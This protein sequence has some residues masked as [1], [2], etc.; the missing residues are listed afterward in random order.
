MAVILG[1]CW[2]QGSLAVGFVYNVANKEIHGVNEFV[3]K[4]VLLTFV[5]ELSASWISRP[6]KSSF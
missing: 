1:A 4:M 2:Y 3:L 6:S 5:L